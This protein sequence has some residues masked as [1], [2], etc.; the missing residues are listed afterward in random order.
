MTGNFIIIILFISSMVFS[1]HLPTKELLDLGVSREEIEISNSLHGD[2]GI[3]RYYLI[4]RLK[5]LSKKT[6]I[7]NYQIKYEL[8]SPEGKLIP[9]AGDDDLISRG[10]L[11][12]FEFIRDEIVLIEKLPSLRN[13]I[14]IVRF[15]LKNGKI[16]ERINADI[17]CEYGKECDWINYKEKT[18]AFFTNN[19]INKGLQNNSIYE[20]NWHLNKF[21]LIFG[22]LPFTIDAATGRN[23]K[24]KNVKYN[25]HTKRFEYKNEI[26]S[27]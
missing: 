20:Y 6:N 9:L 15:D 17:P 27:K 22:K 14:T 21:T 2:N 23:L 8:Y 7:N 18:L 1:Q 10:E 4:S 25:H 11:I 13:Q 26:H 19:V 12:Y 3:G 16:N 5:N 24:L